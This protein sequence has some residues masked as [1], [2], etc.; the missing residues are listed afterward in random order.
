MAEYTEAQQRILS[1]L[2]IQAVMRKELTPEEVVEIRPCFASGMDQ[3][4]LGWSSERTCHCRWT[5]S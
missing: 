1:S 4:G 5:S 3:G 2:V